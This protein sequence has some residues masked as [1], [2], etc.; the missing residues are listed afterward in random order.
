M[1]VGV[2]PGRVEKDVSLRWPFCPHARNC[3][4]SSVVQI[5][6]RSSID[7]RVRVS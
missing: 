3:L 2:E 4:L 5:V 6:V 1:I 7:V